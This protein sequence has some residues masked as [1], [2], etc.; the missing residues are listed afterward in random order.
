M[1]PAVEGLKD[2]E[3]TK[4]MISVQNEL[5]AASRMLTVKAG[6]YPWA[7]EVKLTID[8]QTRAIQDLINQRK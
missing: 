4:L 2:P 7:R 1:H 3:M 5:I 8:M 6:I